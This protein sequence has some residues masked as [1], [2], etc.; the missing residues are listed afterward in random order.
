MTELENIKELEAE[1]REAI[2]IEAVESKEE[3]SDEEI[4]AQE[5]PTVEP[6][7]EAKKPAKKAKKTPPAKKVETRDERMQSSRERERE[8]ELSQQERDER[9]MTWQLIQSAQRTGSFMNGRIS[10]IEETPEGSVHAT[11]KVNGVKIII[12]ASEMGVTPLLD[13]DAVD[14][15]DRKRRE[16]QLLTKNLGAEID[17]IIVSSSLED[18]LDNPRE[19]R[20]VVL[21]SR[22]KALLKKIK[23]NYVPKADGL[24][25]IRAGEIVRDCQVISVG[26]HGLRVEVGGVDTTIP[27]YL[28]TYKYLTDLN[29]EFHVGQKID[30]FIQEVKKSD[31]G[32]IALTASHKHALTP[33]YRRNLRKVSIEGVYMGTIT[34][35]NGDKATIYLDDEDVVGMSKILSVYDTNKLPAAGDRVVFIVKRIIE[36]RGFALGMVTRV[37]KVS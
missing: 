27:K 31:K 6:E 37:I 7:A 10:S 28:L 21:A 32:I 33:I 2:V 18:D 23:D 11:V 30:V 5:L 29:R 22:R 8:R 3:V 14:E 9:N 16:K 12:P 4:V 25:K 13:S 36:E 17:F 15:N 1:V 19:K 26:T 20:L 24:S 35:I 34:T